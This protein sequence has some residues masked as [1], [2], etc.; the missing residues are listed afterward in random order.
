MP[1]NFHFPWRRLADLLAILQLAFGVS[2]AGALR[3]ILVMIKGKR[4]RAWNKL[5]ELALNHPK[6]YE[7]WIR[8]AEPVLAES[9]NLGSSDST[10]S[11]L[12]LCFV[13][14]CAAQPDG[15]GRTVGSLRIAFGGQIEIYLDHGYAEG[16]GVLEQFANNSTIEAIA[17]LSGV[18]SSSAP[19]QDW[20]LAIRAGDL[21]SPYAGKVLSRTIAGLHQPMPLF[22]DEDSLVDGQRCAP[23]LK[24]EFDEWIFL[25]RDCLGGACL[26]PASGVVATIDSAVSTAKGSHA[27]AELVITGIAKGS[28]ARPKHVPL[29]LTHRNGGKDFVNATEW[30]AL[31]GRHWNKPLQ[32]S[33]GTEF[34]AFLKVAPA[35]PAEWPSVSIIIPTRD[36]ASLLAACLTSLEKLEYA[37]PCEIIVVDNGSIELDAVELIEAAR[38]QGLIRVMRQDGPFNFSS[39]N[40]AAARIANGQ[41]LCLMN[42]DV[43]AIDGQWLTNMVLHALDPSVGAV[44][45]RLL[46]PCGSIQHAGV[47]VGMGGAA[48][49]VAKGAAHD[50][51]AHA[52]WHGVTRTVS[53]VTAA[54]LVV[55][56]EAYLMAN[57]LDEEAF[58]VAFN[59]IDFCLKLLEFGLVNRFVAE[60]ELT[61]HESVSRGDDLAPE[62]LARFSTELKSFKMRWRSSEYQD[63]WYSPLLSKSSEACT[64]QF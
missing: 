5:C 12:P 8:H 24:G 52:A 15:V 40:N 41:I 13:L 35:P 25:S 42:N 4:Q 58:P 32:I 31:I 9:C 34:S 53:A 2:P 22:W 26:L 14:D 47:V 1:R 62:N 36:R 29:I 16:C 51:P 54:C 39:L 50:D 27:M 44:G 21:I 60:A 23:W 57:G 46:Y 33:P 63:P 56:R 11:L 3:A 43:T 7:T 55:R 61:H 45:A 18:R 10:G 17:S 20:V 19:A 28:F 64:L 59:D 6:Y 49:H 30:A 48:G 37:G 38:E